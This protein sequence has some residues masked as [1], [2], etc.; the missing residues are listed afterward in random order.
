MAKKY[1]VNITR[2]A[3][4]DAEAIRDYI[5]R[6]R[7]KA[8]D[9]WVRD[10]QKQV[11]DLTLFPLAHEV[12]PEETEGGTEY[13]HRLFKNYRTI[14]R[15]E[16]QDVIILRVIHAARLLDPDSLERHPPPEI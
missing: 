7:P 14:Y 15:V 4:R 16:G 1:R 12:I 2:K 9:R 8:A 3:E 10:F 5:A 6:D 11:A 13:R